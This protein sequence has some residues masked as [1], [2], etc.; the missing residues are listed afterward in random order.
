LLSE[1]HVLL[2]IEFLAITRGVIALLPD[3]SN[4]HYFVESHNA[5]KSNR[6]ALK[7]RRIDLLDMLQLEHFFLCIRDMYFSTRYVSGSFQ[8]GRDF[9][10]IYAVLC[11]CSFRHGY[12]R[13][14][15]ILPSRLAHHRF[16]RQSALRFSY[17]TLQSLD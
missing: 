7:A 1:R 5:A 9:H 3:I 6:N 4:N 11:K 15:A 10:H 12:S 8:R 17:I 2:I 13:E 16:M 14:N